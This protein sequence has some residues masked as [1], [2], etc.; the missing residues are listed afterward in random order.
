MLKLI[1]LFSDH[2]NYERRL[3]SHTV[4]A[5]QADLEHFYTWLKTKIDSEDIL[6]HIDYHHI[7][8]YLAYCHH[9]YKKVS[10]ARRLSVIKTFFRYLINTNIITSSPADYIE[11]PVVTKPLPKPITVE[12]AFSLCDMPSAD[13]LTQRDK[14]IIE[15]LYASGMRISELVSLDIDSIDPHSRLIRVMGKGKK[16]RIIPVHHQCALLLVLY[17]NNIRPKILKNTQEKA[18]FL[19][20]RGERINPRV[21][22]RTLAILGEQ[23]NIN[24]KLHPH[25]LRHAYATHMLESGAD[26]RSIQELLG[27]ASIAT[28]ERYTAIDL[29]SLMKQ[30]DQAHPHAQNNKKKLPD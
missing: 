24:H 21:V 4:S 13:H 9:K 26:L 8:E 6:N 7:R 2:L 27:H 16:E 18:L 1:T 22:R 25:R 3:S 15:L 23:F 11:S 29:S 28:T 10:I 19:G 30:Y 12:E 5:Y 20:K 14:V 17:I